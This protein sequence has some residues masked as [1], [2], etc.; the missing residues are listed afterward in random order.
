MTVQSRAF[1]RSLNLVLTLALECGIDSLAVGGAPFGQG[2]TSSIT[3]RLHNYAAVPKH[4][5]KGA[6]AEAG[7]VLGQAGVELQWVDWPI[8]R[9][10]MECYPVCPQ[11]GGWNTID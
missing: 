9:T 11:T 6:Q 10:D 5:L 2:T 4:T 7:R 3:I 1:W 8:S